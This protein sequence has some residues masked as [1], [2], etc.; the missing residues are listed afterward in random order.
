MISK[1]ARV[2]VAFFLAG[3]AAQ[4]GDPASLASA[5]IVGGE[6]GGNPAVVVLRNFRNGGLCTGALIAERVVLTAKHCVQEAFAEGPVSPSAISVGVGDNVRAV[7]A[8]LR[9]QS[10]STTPGVY[11]TDSRGGIGTGLI[12]EDVAVMVLQS[13]VPGIEPLPIRREPPDDLRGQTITAVGFGQT[14]EGRVGVKYT[15]TGRITGVTGDLIYV[16]A[17]TCQGDSGGPAITEA[18][19]VAGVVSFGA[20]SCGNGYGAY[21]A[22]HSY[23]DMIDAALI[24]AGSCLNDGEERC[25]GADNDCDDQVDEVCTPI[26]EACGADDECVGLTCRE[27]TVGRI[28]T[29]PCD[30]LRPEFGCEPGMYCARTSGCDGFCVPLEGERG[31]RANGEECTRDEEC[32][33]LFCTDPGD[34]VKR[35]LSPCRGDTGMCLA[36]EACVALPGACGACVEEGILND[37]RGLGESCD[38]NADCRSEDCYEDGDRRYCT[39]GCEA[40]ADCGTGFHC[41]VNASE[42]SLSRC[43]AGPRADIGDRCLGDGDCVATALCVRRGEQRWCTRQCSDADPCP[44]GLDCVSAQGTQ[45]CA[46]ALGLDGDE[47]TA[48]DECLSGSCSSDTGTCTRACGPDAPCGIGLECRRVGDAGEATCVAPVAPE[49]PRG[50]SA[51]RSGSSAW[52]WLAALGLALSLRR[53]GR[54]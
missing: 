30:P 8:S 35:C 16:G 28:C 15:T 42:P 49:A 54:A 25:D 27:T 41:R 51:S 29:T 5:P 37:L 20:G 14:P 38:E 2:L 52:L 10:I 7:T 18:G 6:L 12:G 36:G 46:P 23:L 3:C 40:D 4:A 43:A 22:I 31:M 48:D 33:S 47:C 34:R 21:N 19:D 45:V 9:V 39:R 26:G 13:G 44:E 1:T 11:T 24:E 53:R 50:C 32:A 17:I